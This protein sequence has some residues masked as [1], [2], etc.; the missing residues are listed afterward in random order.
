MAKAYMEKPKIWPLATLKPLNRLFSKFALVITSRISPQCKIWARSVWVFFSPYA[1]NIT[2]QGRKKCSFL[3]SSSKTVKKITIKLSSHWHLGYVMLGD[4]TFLIFAVL[5]LRFNQGRPYALF[6]T[7]KFFLHFIF[8]V[9]LHYNFITW[10]W[11]R[12]LCGQLLFFYI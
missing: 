4:T 12:H 9:L 11:S 10:P 7:V 6:W 3:G 1:W 2:P 8:A 5:V